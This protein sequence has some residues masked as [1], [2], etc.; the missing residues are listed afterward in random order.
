[1]EGNKEGS[2]GELGLWQVIKKGQGGPW[3][4]VGNKEGTLGGSEVWQVMQKGQGGTLGSG[5]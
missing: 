2:R 4:L 3:A 5:R 1:M